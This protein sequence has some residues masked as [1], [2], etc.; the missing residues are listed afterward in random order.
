MYPVAIYT[1]I[2]DILTIL[3]RECIRHANSKADRVLYASLY[4]HATCRFSD[5]FMRLRRHNTTWADLDSLIAD[6]QTE[7]DFILS[8]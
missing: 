5:Y 1:A 3:E 7:V 2:H 6:A 8:K 4:T